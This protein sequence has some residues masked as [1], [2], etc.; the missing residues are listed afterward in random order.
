MQRYFIQ[1]GQFEGETARIEGEDAHHLARVMRARPGDVVIVSDGAGREAK[2]QLQSVGTDVVTGVVV[3]LLAAT[4]EPKA[5]VTVAQSLPKGDKMET[6]IQKC[7]EIGAVRFV[8]FLSERTI[9]RYDERK[10]KNRLERWKKIAKE[11]AEQAHRNRIPRV[12]APSSWKE[13]IGTIPQYDAAFLCYERERSRQLRNELR[14]ALGSW[15]GTKEV[16]PWRAILIVGPEGGFTDQE[17]AE[18]EQAGARPVGLGARIL[19][20]ET[21]AMVGLT[22][23]LYETGEMGGST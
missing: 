2:L 6:V 15:T 18:A 1:P 7:T 17:A 3:E 20:A 9:V 22:C 4:Q 8:P 13:L 21:A 16:R 19:R 12:E 5:E 10:E 23:I 11:A 14:I